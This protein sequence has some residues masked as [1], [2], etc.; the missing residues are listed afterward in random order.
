ML[1]ADAGFTY[2]GVKLSK[3]AET[4]FDKRREHRTFALSSMALTVIGAGAM[5]FFNK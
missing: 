1:A 3:E 4:D 5:R 2:A